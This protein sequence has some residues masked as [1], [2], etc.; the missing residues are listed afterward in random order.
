MNK[1]RLPLK[2]R[3]NFVYEWPRHYLQC[4]IRAWRKI[5]EL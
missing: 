5:G 4:L 2:T 1:Y 3:I